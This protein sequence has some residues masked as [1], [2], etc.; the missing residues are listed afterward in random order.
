MALIQ[1]RTQRHTQT[2]GAL[3]V[4]QPNADGGAYRQR[5]GGGVEHIAGAV[6]TGDRVSHRRQLTQGRA[7]R[8]IGLPKLECLRRAARQRT[9]G[10]R[11]IDD[12][13]AGAA[14]GESGDNLTGRNHLPL[15]GQHIGD[16]AV[17]ISGQGGVAATILDLR[18]VG[19]GRGQIGFSHA[20]LG[21]QL[22]M[23]LT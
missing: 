4:L 16:D 20:Q 18:S 5:L 8:R 7:N 21:H 23:R 19:A 2:R 12:G 10:F 13:L 9:L 6:G 22:I 17:G 15:I 11:N 3:A 14:V 1:Q